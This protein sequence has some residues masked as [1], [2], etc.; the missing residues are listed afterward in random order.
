MFRR[1]ILGFALL[2]VSLDASAQPT[3]A[4]ALRERGLVWGSHH[5]TR[6]T[7]PQELG[8]VSAESTAHLLGEGAM[9]R[10][11]RITSPSQS[12]VLKH[13]PLDARLYEDLD[14]DPEDLEDERARVFDEDVVGY[15]L[16]QHI[17]AE[18]GDADNFGAVRLL[19]TDAQNHFLI[20]SNANGQV[21]ADLIRTLGEDHPVIL[22]LGEDY[23]RRL[24]NAAAALAA[25][26]GV[27]DVE[28]QGEDFP[29]LSFSYNGMGFLLD[30]INTLVDTESH[31]MTLFD[32]I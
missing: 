19:Q 17:F 25:Y 24:K 15:G 10:A 29:E 23:N 3:C 16:L 11:Y 7:V 31:A 14:Y 22:S 18:A 12:V 9:G 27:E 30:S 6:T 28:I 26:P 2:T 20:L 32:P 4:Q 8:F 13:F 1:L 21:L 5:G